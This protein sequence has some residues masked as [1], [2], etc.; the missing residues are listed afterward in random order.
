MSF[1]TNRPPGSAPALSG[2]SLLGVAG[3][4]AAA[5]LQAQT[6]NDLR[7]LAPAQWHWSGWLNPKGRVIALFALLKLAEDDFLLLLPDFP[8]AQLLPLLQRY[9][10]R[11]KLRL[12]VVSD[13][14]AAADRS[15]AAGAEERHDD[16]FIGDRQSGLLLDFGGTE[17]RRNLLLLPPD[18]PLLAPPDPAC[19]AEWL[20]QDLSHGLPRLPASQS[21][22]WTPQMLSLERLHAFSLKKGCYPGQ[23]IVARTHYLGQAR[24]SLGYLEGTEL[25]PG[26]TLSGVDGAAI[27][28]VISVTS[29][30][31]AGLAVLQLDKR[32]QETRIGDRVVALSRFSEGLQRPV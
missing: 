25:E 11:S 19:D 27:G 2:F 3:P 18:C 5:F 30:R 20:A 7:A 12:Q 13:L 15:P 16:R 1:K 26:A 10:F 6:M 4:E 17:L 31:L 32:T 8:A 24:R 23:E 14:V 22:A 21:E 9:V 29:D 28:T